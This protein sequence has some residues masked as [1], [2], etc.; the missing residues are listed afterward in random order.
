MSKIANRINGKSL[1]SPKPVYQIEILSPTMVCGW[2]G[3]EIVDPEDIALAGITIGDV[4]LSPRHDVETQIGTK[5]TGFTIY[6][7][8]KIPHSKLLGTKILYENGELNNLQPPIF[9]LF[10]YDDWE[11][12]LASSKES[13]IQLVAKSGFFDS[14]YYA[15]QLGNVKFKT[16]EEAV[17]HYHKMGWLRGLNPHPLFHTKFY[18]KV[19]TDV[20][21]HGAN[22]LFHYLFSGISENRATTPDFDIDFYT[23]KYGKNIPAG[24]SALQ[25]YVFYGY[26]HNLQPLPWLDSITVKAIS[27]HSPRVCSI[28][29]VY[30]NIYRRLLTPHA[31]MLSASITPSKAH[32]SSE[33]GT[34]IIVPFYREPYLIKLCL[35]SLHR[36]SDELRRLNCRIIAILDSPDDE[37]SVEAFNYFTKILSDKLDIE[38]HINA[39]NIGFVSSVNIGLRKSA[40]EKRNALLL[41]SDCILVKGSI[42]EM[43][44]VLSLDPMIGFVNPR[45]NNATIATYPKIVCDIGEHFSSFNSVSS[46]LPEV[47]YAPT[48]V[49]FCMLISNTV[50]SNFGLLDVSYG[51]GYNEENDY[52]SRANRVGFRAAQANRAYAFHIGGTS[53]RHTDFS[54]SSNV[55]V[56]NKRYPEYDK[57]VQ[58]YFGSRAQFSEQIVEGFLPTTNGKIKVL[59]DIS[60]LGGHPN[61]TSLMATRLIREMVDIE[62]NFELH[63]VSTEQ[64]IKFNQLESIANITLHSGWDTVT[65]QQTKF[66]HIFRMGQPFSMTDLRNVLRTGAT[67]SFFMLDTIALDCGYISNPE[68]LGTWE[69]VASS[70][71]GFVY[72]SE[73]TRNQF[74]RRFPDMQDTPNLVSYH[75]LSLDEY[76]PKT[77]RSLPAT[78]SSLI[79]PAGLKG[80]LSSGFVLLVGNHFAHKDVIATFNHISMS[81]PHIPIVVIGD[82]ETRKTAV[83]AHGSIFLKSGDIRAEVMELLYATARAVIFPSFYEGFGLPIFDALSQNR[84]LFLRDSRINREIVTAIGVSSNSNNVVFYNDYADLV[85]KFSE[86][87]DMPAP[88]SIEQDRPQTWR[89]SAVEIC[90]FIEKIIY[91]WEPKHTYRNYE[92][93]RSQ[94]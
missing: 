83:N 9:A 12:H 74:E 8:S 33:I 63:V 78:E 77:V 93:V 45:S 71:S 2:I 49:G 79:Q 37:E 48:C 50:I 28:A 13:I 57:Q 1:N 21:R 4:M 3:T 53:F 65:R 39:V 5:A 20:A 31:A 47:S 35:E 90:E 88:T 41:N 58:M 24:I 40:F 91:A 18:L 6:P 44:R 69:A 23:A 66:A 36:I 70:A 84:R 32:L 15:S 16:D 7:N 85:L 67:H 14:H 55:E 92:L 61:G 22:P 82:S 30:R 10:S 27:Q 94:L 46:K 56:L 43:L 26:S 75:S 68:M 60:Q 38:S 59:L 87:I 17:E 54:S 86:H 76:R 64:S 81:H 62:H 19:N 80:V 11:A 29:E 42:T 25:H 52:V 51:A 34:N 73:F 89:S 72:Q